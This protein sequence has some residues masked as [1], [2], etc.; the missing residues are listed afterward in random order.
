MAPCTTHSLFEARAESL[1]RLA[2]IVVSYT[3]IL[4]SVC[5]HSNRNTLINSFETSNFY[6]RHTRLQP[7]DR[8]AICK[9]YYL[10]HILHTLTQTCDDTVCVWRAIESKCVYLHCIHM[11]KFFEEWNLVW[12]AAASIKKD[13]S[14]HPKVERKWQICAHHSVDDASVT[15]NSRRVNH[16]RANRNE[17][18][19]NHLNVC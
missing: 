1:C 13:Y 19:N 17:S 10:S 18:N 5:T 9:R 6:T 4:D 15:S 7:P 11:Q 8:Q 16:R 3:N 12:C 14:W 2:N